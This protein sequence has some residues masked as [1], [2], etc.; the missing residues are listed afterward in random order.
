MQSLF[1]SS[2]FT[3]FFHSP[4]G[5][6][7][8]LHSFI[9]LIFFICHLLTLLIKRILILNP[10]QSSNTASAAFIMTCLSPFQDSL[11][12][13][14]SGRPARRSLIAPIYLVATHCSSSFPLFSFLA[15]IPYIFLA[16]DI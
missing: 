11:T 12:F 16:L 2:R 6:T 1:F 9:Y 14:L 10:F 13:S 5:M 15:W 4:S 7:P 8:L 3:V